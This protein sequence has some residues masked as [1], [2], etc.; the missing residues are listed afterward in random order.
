MA[1][2]LRRLRQRKLVQWALA[3]IAFAF[4]LLQGVDIVAQRFAWPEQIERVLILLLALGFFVAVVLAWY[5]GEREVRGISGAEIV[6]LALLLAIG[7]GALWWFARTTHSTTASVAAGPSDSLT[8]AGF[9]S[10]VPAKSVAVLPMSN[11]NGARDDQYFSDGLSEDLITALSQ[12]AGLKVIS[13]NSSF[14]FRNSSLSS[15]AIGQALGVAHLL[16]GS[17]QRLDTQVRINAELVNAA[18]GS[19]LWSQ[20]YDRPY[21]DLFALQDE[22]TKAVADALKARLLD[23]GG[24]AIQSDRPPGGSLDAWNA[25][26]RGTAYADLFTLD[27]YRA[28][29]ESFGQAIALDPH[30]A[31]AYAAQAEAWT[32]LGANF[33]DAREQ[34]DAYARARVL[35]DRALQLA[36]NLAAAHTTHGLLLQW[37]DLD[38]NAAE[39]EYR[40]ALQLAPNDSAAKFRLGNLH[41]VLGHPQQA[42]DLMRQVISTDPRTRTTYYWYGWNLA[43]LGRLAEAEQAIRMEFGLAPDAYGL[44]TGLAMILIQRGEARAALA[45]A[46][47]E[48][49]GRTR[50]VGMALALQAVGDS[51]AAAAAL[52]KLIDQS[53]DVMTYQIAE[54]YALRGDPDN[55]FLWLD[56]AWDNRD[57]GIGR[58]L[59]DPFILKYRND[60]RFAKFCAKVG[61][62]STTEAEAMQ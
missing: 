58:L 20:H 30:Y 7:G 48:S 31:R 29:I 53:A 5:H 32:Y 61:L 39:G 57:A 56:R 34:R 14:Q 21:K 51:A 23:G 19:T 3:Y 6:I 55:T 50:D 44:Q 36:P 8:A 22:I 13:R 26:T 41:G 47:L 2:F 17:V 60:P 24:A 27:D 59:T 11:E 9:F 1:D 25:Y 62:P 46:R 4:A 49:S 28:A 52:K 16:E 15:A 35:I 18:D 54:V 12:F 10:T 42:L 38:W 40:R 43:A 33:L 45:A 37:A